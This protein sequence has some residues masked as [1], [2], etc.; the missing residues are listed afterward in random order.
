M[1]S[2]FD[3]KGKKVIVALPA[4][5]STIPVEWML[6][7]I[8]TLQLAAQYGLEVGILCRMGSS[9]IPKCRNE[10]THQ[11]L[12]ET[13]ADYMFCI[14]SDVIWNPEDFIRQVAYA[15]QM[16][17]V[18]GPYPVKQD[19]PLF[20]AEYMV[21]DGKSVG[22]KHLLRIISGPA[23]FLC[24]SRETL[25]KIRDNNPDLDYEARNG[26]FVDSD[27]KINAMWD[28]MI[29][30]GVYR[31]EDIAFCIRHNAAGERMW[32]DTRTHLKHVGTK[33]YEY[34]YNEY[35]NDK[36]FGEN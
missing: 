1:A 32:M 14:D 8:R 16:G 4:G 15:T 10:I 26:D 29:H 2:S 23:G 12:Y 18:M 9:L 36:V 7:Y 6:A 31:G 35:L 3:L 20:H 24:V 33:V 13:D 28:T 22:E 27:R 17:T 30:D 19:E 34:D 11:F 5:D 25:E 21:Q